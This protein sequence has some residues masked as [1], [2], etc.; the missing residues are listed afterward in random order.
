MQ[1]TK[2]PAMCADKLKVLADATRLAVLELL[3]ESPR[4]VREMNQRLGIEQSLLSHHLKTLRDSGFVVA[5]RDGKTI[6]YRLAPELE[7]TGQNKALNL[8]CCVLSF[9]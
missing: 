8:G 7:A 1:G 2:P 3:M 4:Q 9:P 5:E 6:R